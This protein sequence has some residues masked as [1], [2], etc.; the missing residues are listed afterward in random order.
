LVSDKDRMYGRFQ[1]EI[2]E[3]RA[4]RIVIDLARST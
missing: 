4:K 1:G 3:E 2:A